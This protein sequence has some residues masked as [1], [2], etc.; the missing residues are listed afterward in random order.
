MSDK[1]TRRD[2]LKLSSAGVL[3]LAS[4]KPAKV[5]AEAQESLN[6]DLKIEVVSWEGHSFYPHPINFSNRVDFPSKVQDPPQLI[7]YSITE[8]TQRHLKE[9]DK[10]SVSNNEVNPI[11]IEPT[12]RIIED[13]E[14]E[15]GEFNKLVLDAATVPAYALIASGLMRMG[16]KHDKPLITAVG[17]LVFTTGLF[18]AVCDAFSRPINPNDK[19][20]YERFAA[21]PG[22][23][24]PIKPQF[25][26]IRSI[27]IMDA[28]WSAMDSRYK[29]E[30][31]LAISESHID[32]LEAFA[33]KKVEHLK[34]LLLFD[35]RFDSTIMKNVEALGSV[36]AVFGFSVTDVVTS[37]KE[38]YSL[39]DAKFIAGLK[40]K[41]YPNIPLE[42]IPGRVS[43]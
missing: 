30:P 8:N 42:Q 39:T 28:V 7:S 2:F 21:E 31:I 12:H 35:R 6:T 41:L 20:Y 5:L 24:Y 43:V 16:S 33:S 18:K 11:F 40:R 36:E 23:Y 29:T 38:D 4:R 10:T 9:K 3:A 26:S 34:N 13:L 19:S 32:G 14:A 37:H 22:Q 1:I 25:S 15:K 27:I 17:G